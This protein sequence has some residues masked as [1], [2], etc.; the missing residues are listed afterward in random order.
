[1][2][3]AKQCPRCHSPRDFQYSFAAAVKVNKLKQNIISAWAVSLV[4][5]P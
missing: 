5:I 2:V 1:M 3:K 4:T